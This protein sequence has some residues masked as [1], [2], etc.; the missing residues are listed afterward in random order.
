M[1]NSYS[2][3]LQVCYSNFKFVSIVRIEVLQVLL[4][5]FRTDFSLMG[6]VRVMLMK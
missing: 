1:T 4:R 2:V 6:N 5:N 3:N